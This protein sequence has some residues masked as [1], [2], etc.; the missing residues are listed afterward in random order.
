MQKIYL[1]GYIEY[2]KRKYT[3]NFEEKK[4][5]LIST[6][7]EITFFEG[8][9]YVDFF[10]G[11][12]L[13]G[14]DVV[15][16]IKNKIYYKDGCY[17][18][19][20]RSILIVKEDYLRISELNFDSIKIVGGNINRFYSNKK[21]ISY[22]KKE[23]KK[24]N[25]NNFVFKNEEETKLKE[26]VCINGTKTLFELFI[27]H[28]RWKDDGSYNFG[29]F[30]SSVRINYNYA[31]NYKKVIQDIAKTERMFQFCANRN[32]IVFENIFLEIQ[33]SE[34]KHKSVAE[35][36]VPYMIENDVSKYMINYDTLS[37]HIS[38][39]IEIL[40]NS[41]YVLSII[42]N[43]E[44]EHNTITN[45]DYCAVFS[46]FQFVNNYKKS[47]SFDETK[48]D[49]YEES[50]NEIK[51]EILAFLEEKD[52]EYYGKDRRKRGYIKSFINMVNVSNLKLEKSIVKELVERQYLIETLN[53]YEIKEKINKMGLQESTEYAVRIRDY[54]THNN[55]VN[56]DEVAI[57]MYQ[58]ITRLNY[59]I[60]LEK[61]EIEK[62]KVEKIIR[63]LTQKN[64]I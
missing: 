27:Q 8:H 38:N 39:L 62:V 37:G 59:A 29:Q 21:M 36:I 25:I 24:N 15:F 45:K 54:I 5:V 58:I 44:S 57:G 28:P 53:N 17:I 46:C 11:Q 2:N 52:Q 42:P 3:F 9:Q 41:N 22:N 60:I 30:D 48:E 18:C 13:D 40:N 61:A 12:T 32:N 6:E 20:P 34:N 1:R 23:Y 7:N 10:E 19:F 16:H 56:L 63:F 4:L 64:V 47:E 33:D 55:I 50:L 43:D 26:T 31:V 49:K 51:D 14:F 35:I